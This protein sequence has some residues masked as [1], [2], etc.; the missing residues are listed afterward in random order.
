[1][2]WHEKKAFLCLKVAFCLVDLL[3]GVDIVAVRSRY[4]RRPGS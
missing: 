1:M 3:F 2:E 4:A